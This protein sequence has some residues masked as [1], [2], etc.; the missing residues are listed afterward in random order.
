MFFKFDRFIAAVAIVA[1]LSGC[2]G[3]PR[4]PDV[5]AIHGVVTLDGNPVPDAIVEFV[6]EKGRPSEGVTDASGRY[7]LDYTQSQKGAITG[8]H[9]VKITTFR[10]EIRLEGKITQKGVRESIPPQYNSQSKLTADVTSES[11]EVNFTLTSK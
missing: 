3:G 4:R 11:S 1:A 5:V 7:D 10:E 6:P 2:G 8:K 9:T